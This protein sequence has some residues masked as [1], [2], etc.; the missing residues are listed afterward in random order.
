M[1]PTDEELTCAIDVLRWFRDAI[2]DG[3]YDG[4]GLNNMFVRTVKVWLENERDGC[5]LDIEKAPFHLAVASGL[6]TNESEVIISN[7]SKRVKFE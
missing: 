1:R 5:Y 2:D 4:W 3:L 7:E 6:N